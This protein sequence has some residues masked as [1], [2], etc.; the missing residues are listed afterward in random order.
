MR[1]AD[2]GPDPDRMLD[3]AGFPSVQEL[4]VG[5]LYPN[6]LER[7]VRSV[8]HVVAIVTMV[9]LS[10]LMLFL[11]NGITTIADRLSEDPAPAVTG[12]PFGDLECGG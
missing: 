11:L 12:C 4:K 2:H 1:F 5:R 7:T 8:M 3:Q 9:L 10:L 6:R